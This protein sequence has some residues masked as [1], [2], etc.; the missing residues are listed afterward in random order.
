MHIKCHLSAWERFALI[1]LKLTT[2]GKLAVLASEM[3]P[4]QAWPQSHS[5]GE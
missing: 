2:S 5:E 3:W 4:G 1:S